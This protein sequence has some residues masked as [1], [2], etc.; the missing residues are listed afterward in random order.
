MK[1]NLTSSTVF[2]GLVYTWKISIQFAGGGISSS[3]V[4]KCRFSDLM[5]QVKITKRIT[6]RHAETSPKKKKKSAMIVS[7]HCVPSYYS[8]NQF[9]TMPYILTAKKVTP[10]K[11]GFILYCLVN[12]QS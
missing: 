7:L 9:K 6:V 12:F 10:P 8:E 1:I 2:K 5:Q 11:K 3:K 4:E